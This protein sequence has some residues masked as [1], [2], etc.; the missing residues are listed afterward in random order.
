[1]SWLMMRY[2]IMMHN[3]I[4]MHYIIL[5]HHTMMHYTILIHYTI[6]MH[7]TISLWLHRVST[8]TRR[9]AG[10]SCARTRATRIMPARSQISYAAFA[11]ETTSGANA[12]VYRFVRA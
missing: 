11:R 8:R 1:M 7:N 12:H 10:G 6:T 2:T 3:T 5:M 4:M 9:G